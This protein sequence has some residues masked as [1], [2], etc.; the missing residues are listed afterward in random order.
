[1]GY[2]SPNIAGFTCF[3]EEVHMSWIIRLLLIIGLATSLFAQSDAQDDRYQK[4]LDNYKSATGQ[5]VAYK[6][7]T[8]YLQNKPPDEQ[9]AK[10]LGDWAGKYEKAVREFQVRNLIQQKNFNEAAKQGKQ[11]L[12]TD[13]DNLNLLYDVTVAAVQAGR[14]ADVSVPSEGIESALHAMKLLEGGSPL[15][16]GDLFVTRDEGLARLNFFV[17]HLKLVKNEP[18]GAVSYLTEALHH[19]S[20][21]K[22]APDVY[23]DLARAYET[24]PYKKLI[25][26]YNS[27]FA[28][29]P[30]TE[31][32][33]AALAKINQV[34][35][36]AIDAYARAVAL[37]NGKAELHD[38]HEKWLAHLTELYKSR[39][40]GSDAGL[41]TMISTVLTLPLPAPPA[42]DQGSSTQPH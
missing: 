6:A 26:V 2:A 16:P 30:E 5:Q 42:V 15:P 24:G 27:Q 1:M 11:A 36:C 8:E 33:K 19:E 7:A 34:I 21:L 39:H 4:F 25:P 12:L 37:S 29:K 41:E 23:N 32:G 10:F 40:D 38:A 20:D 18:E 17:G 3:A 28:D 14:N 22:K 35:D 9:I 13:P 31:E